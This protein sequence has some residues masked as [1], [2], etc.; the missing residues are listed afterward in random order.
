RLQV[1]SGILSGLHEEN[2][3]H[4]EMLEAFAPKDQLL[5][6]YGEARRL[7]YR[8]HEYGDV[9]LIVDSRERS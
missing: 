1:V 9:N 7:G 3:S 8:G 5:Q 6:A 4:L 2:S